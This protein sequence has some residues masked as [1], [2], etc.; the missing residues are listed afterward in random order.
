MYSGMYSIVFF[1]DLDDDCREMMCGGS[2]RYDYIYNKFSC[3]CPE[4]TYLNDD[5]SSCVL[6][7]ENGFTSK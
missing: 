7:E 6:F 5:G 4:N 3:T 1:V 2:C